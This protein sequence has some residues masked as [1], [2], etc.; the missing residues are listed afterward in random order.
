MQNTVFVKGNDLLTRHI[1]GETLIVPVRGRVGDL[2]SI[3]T[4]NEVGLSIW[5]LLDG[6]ADVAQ[7]AKAISEEYDVPEAEAAQDVTELLAS[8][9]EVGLVAAV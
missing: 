4:L 8:M 9:A 7:I 2:D 6:R 3:F 5:T 1:A